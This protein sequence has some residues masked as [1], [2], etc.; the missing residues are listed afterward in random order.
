MIEM[1]YLDLLQDDIIEVMNKKTMKAETNEKRKER[2]KRRKN[3]KGK[4]R[5]A[6]QY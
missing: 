5:I 1:N 6:E 3:Q 4:K 2:N